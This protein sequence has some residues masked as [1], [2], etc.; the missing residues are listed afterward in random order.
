MKAGTFAENGWPDDAALSM[1]K[2]G[3][4]LLSFSYDMEFKKNPERNIVVNVCD[5]GHVSTNMSGYKGELTIE[6]GQLSTHSTAAALLL[7]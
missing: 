1:S 4:A 6:E 7:D 5:P 3:D 2:L